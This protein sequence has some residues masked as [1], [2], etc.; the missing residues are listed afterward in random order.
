MKPWKVFQRERS[1][2]KRLLRICGA[3]LRVATT[4]NALVNVRAGDAKRLI[5]DMQR[6][7]MSHNPRQISP[8]IFQRYAAMLIIL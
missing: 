6:P 7:L 3:D 8:K 4:G 5:N 1:N 2:A